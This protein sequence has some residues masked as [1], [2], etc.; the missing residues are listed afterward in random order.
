MVTPAEAAR[1]TRFFPMTGGSAEVFVPQ[2]REAAA[3]KRA[4]IL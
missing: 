2:A 3:G 4:D 1:Q